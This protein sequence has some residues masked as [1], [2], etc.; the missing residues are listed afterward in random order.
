M[1]C[2]VISV[3]IFIASSCIFVSLLTKRVAIYSVYIFGVVGIAFFNRFVG[4][5]ALCEEIYYYVNGP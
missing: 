4:F 3:S 1:N 5:L 2:L